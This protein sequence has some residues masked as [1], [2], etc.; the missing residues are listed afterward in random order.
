MPHFGEWPGKDYFKM[1][2]RDHDSDVVDESPPIQNEWYPVFEAE[3]VRLIWCVVHQSNTEVAAKDIEVRWT[4][5][6]T[7]YLVAF[8]LADSTFEYIYRHYQPSA[9]GVQGLWHVESDHT[10]GYFTDKRGQSFKVEVRITS[11]L[12]T[13]QRLRCYCVRE[14]LEQT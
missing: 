4:I 6:G 9:G 3:D 11:P 1:S 5:D 8:S 7:P 10:A 2:W 13:A 12:G 14:T